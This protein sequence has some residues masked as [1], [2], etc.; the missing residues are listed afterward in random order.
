MRSVQSTRN[1]GF[2]YFPFAVGDEFVK[3]V[4]QFSSASIVYG[5]I[6]N[7]MIILSGFFN[8]LYFFSQFLT[9][10]SYIPYKLDFYII[11]SQILCEIVDVGIQ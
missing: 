2:C 5:Y 1:I 6:K 3:G 9:K 7:K 8:S 4:Y 11:F 10:A